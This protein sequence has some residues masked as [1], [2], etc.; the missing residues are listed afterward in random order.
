MFSKSILS[1]FS[2]FKTWTCLTHWGFKCFLII[3][4]CVDQKCP[5]SD[6]D[7]DGPALVGGNGNHY[8]GPWMSYISI[9]FCSK[10]LQSRAW[11]SL[12]WLKRSGSQYLVPSAAS[13]RLSRGKEQS[14]QLWLGWVSIE[15]HWSKWLSQYWMGHFHVNPGISQISLLP[16]ML[17]WD[18]RISVE[19]NPSLSILTQVKDEV[20]FPLPIWHSFFQFPFRLQ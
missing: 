12:T 2:E 17:P 18:P 7:N 15:S 8:T 4:S 16:L 19:W 6:I 3:G 20:S 13:E 5:I 11:G 1:L 9:E 14:I 10:C